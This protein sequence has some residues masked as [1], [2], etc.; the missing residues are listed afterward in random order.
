MLLVLVARPGIEGK[1]GKRG[2][3]KRR[4]FQWKKKREKSRRKE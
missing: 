2:K 4:R 3:G 1:R